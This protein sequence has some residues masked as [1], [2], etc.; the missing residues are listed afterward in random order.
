MSFHPLA[1]A[2][3]TEYELLSTIR[4][5]FKWNVRWVIPIPCIFTELQRNF[6]SRPYTP[7]VSYP[8]W[9]SLSH[10]NRRINKSNLTLSRREK[11]KSFIWRQFWYTV[12]RVFSTIMSR[13]R[14]TLKLSPQELS[15]VY[16]PLLTVQKK[17]PV[18]TLSIYKR[19][20][21]VFT[22]VPVVQDLS[23]SESTASWRWSPHLQT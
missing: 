13:W 19:K 17:E 9:L 6:H 1:T 20:A 2:A 12:I 5:S 11:P 16:T 10:F 4:S 15:S 7:G 3:T 14:E 18:S 22:V 23:S 21:K 8:K